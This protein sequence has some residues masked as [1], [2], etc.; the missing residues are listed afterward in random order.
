LTTTFEETLQEQLDVIA[1]HVDRHTLD[2]MD[3]G[4]INALSKVL[5][6]GIAWTLTDKEIINLYRIT[7]NTFL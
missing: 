3:Y 2:N 1:S 5:Y 6:D 4:A 7:A